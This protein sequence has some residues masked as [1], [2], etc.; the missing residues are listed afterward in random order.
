MN[1]VPS[2]DLH[3]WSA[4][5]RLAIENDCKTAILRA[6]KILNDEFLHRAIVGQ[7]DHRHNKDHFFLAWKQ[8]LETFRIVY[9]KE[10]LRE[11]L[12][13]TPYDVTDGI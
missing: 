2:K 1:F 10:V 12:A 11:A 6:R 9:G 4:V 7:V 13:G 8:L 3:C 5:N